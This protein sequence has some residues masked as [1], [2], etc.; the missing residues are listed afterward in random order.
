MI[1][2]IYF[3]V[4]GVVVK[5]FSASN[6]WDLL[7]R[8]LGISDNDKERFN[9]LW[10]DHEKEICTKLPV[11][12]MIPLLEKEFGVVIPKSHSILKNFVKYFERNESIW[13]VIDQIKAKYKIGLLTSMYAGMFD[14]ILKKNI[15]PS[16]VWNTIIDSSLVGFAKPDK[17]I[18]EIAQEKVQVS[19]QKILFVENSKINIDAAKKLDW[20]TFWYDSADYAGSSQKLKEYIEMSV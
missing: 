8:D 13:P 1:S 5:D 9:I 17:R 12:D 18:F 4:G 16:T 20:Q 14:E 19:P 6:K 3:D 2:F 7:R 15:L 10:R 11:E